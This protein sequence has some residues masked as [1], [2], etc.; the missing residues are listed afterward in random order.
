MLGLCAH[1][2]LSA[3]ETNREIPDTDAQRR[4]CPDGGLD[5]WDERGTAVL[6]R[7]SSL[8]PRSWNHPCTPTTTSSTLCTLKL[9][10]LPELNARKRKGGEQEKCAYGAESVQLWSHQRSRE[11]ALDRGKSAE[12]QL[13]AGTQLQFE[14]VLR[15]PSAAVSGGGRKA[16][17][18]C[19]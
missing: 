12:R 9:A 3:L 1:C 11:V 13:D 17:A 6:T 2:P 15:A 8:G 10:A 14:V 18:R 4:A 16:G 19:R 5:A 7:Q